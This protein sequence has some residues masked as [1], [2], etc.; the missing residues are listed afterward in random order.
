LFLY[1]LLP[2]ALLFTFST[3][4]KI[5]IRFEIYSQNSEFISNYETLF[6]PLSLI[7][8]VVSGFVFSGFESRDTMRNLDNDSFS[9]GEKLN[10]KVHYGLINAGEAELDVD[11][12]IQMI[13]GRLATK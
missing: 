12:D 6:Y 8:T 13:N 7:L 2:E 4:L 1:S 5:G 3:V 9:T 10:Y 11:K